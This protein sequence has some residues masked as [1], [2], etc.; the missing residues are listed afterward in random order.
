MVMAY[1]LSQ[2]LRRI[3][4]IK[5]GLVIPYFTRLLIIPIIYEPDYGTTLL[6]A[7]LVFV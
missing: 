4:E 6:I 7:Q 5:Y 2:N 3:N 1:W